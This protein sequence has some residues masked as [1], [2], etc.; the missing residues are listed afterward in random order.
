ME[1]HTKNL[2][3]TRQKVAGKG[4]S[5]SITIDEAGERAGIRVIMAHQVTLK[6]SFDSKSKGVGGGGRGA[7]GS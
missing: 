5:E 3:Q 1:H 4:A 6:T 7:W 2:W